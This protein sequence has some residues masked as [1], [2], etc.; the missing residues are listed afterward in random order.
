MKK[1]IILSI[2]GVVFLG[3]VVFQI[4][5]NSVDTINKSKHKGEWVESKV[6]VEANDFFWEQFH[7]GNYDSIPA[8]LEQ[9]TAAYLDNPN[10]LKT[11]NHLGFTHMW[12]IAEQQSAKNPSSTI[13]GH[14]V[15]A[16]KYFGESYMLNPHDT[17]ILSFLSSSK[18]VTGSISKDEGLIR[19]GYF[20]GLKA[21]RE[22]KDF[23]A[24][25]LAYTLSRLPHD[26]TNYAKAL[27][28][29]EELANRCYCDGQN[30]DPESEDCIRF[31]SQRVEE[32]KRLGKKRVVPNSWVAPHNVEGFFMTWGDLLVK[33]GD[34]EKGASIYAFAKH[35]PDY[36]NWDYKDVLERRL[37]HAQQNVTVF[38]KEVKAGEK[39]A[40]DHTVL[41]QT[42]IAC[43]SCHQMSKNEIASTYK[44][45]DHY[46]YLDKAFYFL[47]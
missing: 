45:F 39:V 16:S 6:S 1:K 5:F 44:N 29:M 27:A 12:A 33:H 11:I 13:I 18:I 23:S 8:I 20:N 25:S 15:L 32:P 2:A 31:V 42:A 24:F 41:V 30:F 43:R 9:L 38:R 26:D 22:W 47:E 3:I 35:A 19:E 14:S 46:T 4:V 40:V 17:R 7:L 36:E 37:T 28:W 21:I 34:W 10:D